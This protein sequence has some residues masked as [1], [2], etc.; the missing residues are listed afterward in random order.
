MRTVA[1]V[2]RAK[3]TR[4]FAPFDKPHIDIWAFNDYAMGLPRVSGVFE[5]HADCLTTDR[6]EEEYRDWLRQPHPFPIWM[7]AADPQI[8]ASLAFPRHSISALYSGLWH[9]AE[10]VQDFYTSTTPYALALAI[11]KH[12]T[13]VELYGIELYDNGYR[14]QGDSIFFWLGQAAARGIEVAIH[15]KSNLYRDALYPLKGD[16]HAKETKTPERTGY[17]RIR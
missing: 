4:D 8:P 16:Y 12:Y 1:I 14:K 9:G 17:A 3:E 11:Y 7:H 13:R 5:T 10:K 15:E 6:Y 2:G